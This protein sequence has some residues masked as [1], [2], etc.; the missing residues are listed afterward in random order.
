MIVGN[1]GIYN[2][3]A[4]LRITGGNPKFNCKSNEEPVTY[5]CLKAAGLPFSAIKSGKLFKTEVDLEYQ[6]SDG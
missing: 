5:D 2:S 1:G 4:K 3:C 6:I